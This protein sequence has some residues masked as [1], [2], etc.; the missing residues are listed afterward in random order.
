MDAWIRENQTLVLSTL[1]ML[2]GLMAAGYSVLYSRTVAY[3]AD[4]Q[5][6][7]QTIQAS[8][9]E[10]KTKLGD[11][12][13]KNKE[14]DKEAKKMEDAEKNDVG[15]QYLPIF[16]S[17]INEIAHNNEVIIRRLSPDQAE[18]MKF[19]LEFITDYPTFI[20][21]TSEL[22]SLD[23]TLDDIQLHPYDA[24]KLPPLHAISFSLIPRND[25][26]QLSGQRLE[27]LKQW[28]L[29]KD[30]RNPFQR[31]AYDVSR[32]RISPVIEL[33]WIYKLGG[34]GTTPEG[35]PY[36]NINRRNYMV[37]DELD[38]RIIERIDDDRVFLKK[39]NRDGTVRYMLTFRRVNSDKKKKTP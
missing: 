12:V 11:W 4:M 9:K 7:L 14:K 8:N 19:V 39:T 18:Q 15:I 25:A 3:R 24:T 17:R 33:T 16:L 30:K 35:K 38:G 27:E 20:R 32:K 29:E 13:A 37:G 1:Y 23:I 22:E 6:A 10:M 5:V 26:R 31:F 34:L 2:L 28:I 36:A 21:F